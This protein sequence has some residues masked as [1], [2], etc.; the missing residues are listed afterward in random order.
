[1]VQLPRTGRRTVAVAAALLTGLV[2]LPAIPA[3]AHGGDSG[4]KV[5]ASN[6]NNPRHLRWEGNSLYVAE[7][8]VGGDGPCVTGAEGEACYGKSGSITRLKHGRQSRVVKGLP[9]IAGP[10]GQSANGASDVSVSGRRFTVALGL[11]N[12]PAV[13]ASLPRSGQKLGTISTGRFG[14][15]GLKVAADIG[16]YETRV[17]PDGKQVDTNPVAL[18][19]HGKRA[20]VVDAGGN[21][22]LG[23]SRS[24]RISTRAVFPSVDVPAPDFLG[25]PPGTQIPMDA[26]PTAA[27][28]GPD[29]A[30]YVSQLTGFPF[31]VGGSS[32][33]RVVPGHTPTK[34][35]TGLTNVTDLAFGR[36]GSLYAVQLADE[37]L[38][39][40]QPTG[41]VVRI[42]RG[43]GSTHETFADNLNFPYGIAL[44][45][46]SAY[47]TTCSACA[48]TGQV[49]KIELPH[50]N[51]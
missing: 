46:G 25:L 32:I 21:S 22:L 15:R 38:L 39:A 50:Q 40:P 27:A 19:E 6:L 31:P 47:V 30:V 13:R 12:D 41:S 49:L 14:Q 34:Y 24:G 51:V 28:Y 33:W 7:A 42:P 23:L 29:G 8:G 35:A 16:A 11:G 48:G 1:M 37:G 36:D 2:T 43:G 10:E 20:L 45:K 26:V 3:S 9:S 18:L 4:A 5:V 17:N 44:H